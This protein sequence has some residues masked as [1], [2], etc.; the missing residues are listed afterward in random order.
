MTVRFECR[1]SVAASIEDVFEL[2]LSVDAHQASMARFGER[3]IGGVT[4]GTLHLGDEV[5]WR[6][7][8]LGV[9][10]TMTSQIAELD[11]PRRFVDQQVRGPFARFRHEHTFTEVGDSPS[12]EDLVTFDAPLGVI[13]VL[14]EPLVRHH[15]RTL[16]EDR[17]EFLRRS[18]EAHR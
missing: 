17:N 7:R 10:W 12:M 1:T 9:T 18:A 11:R 13:G 8:H 3:A 14:V 16:I 4:S 2:A 6:A 15:L 5:T